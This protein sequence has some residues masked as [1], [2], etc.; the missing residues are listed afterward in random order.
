VYNLTDRNL[1]SS[2]FNELYVLLTL[3]LIY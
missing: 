1:T 3:M 2:T